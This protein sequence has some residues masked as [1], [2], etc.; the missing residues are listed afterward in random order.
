M[1][2]NPGAAKCGSTSDAP[3][4]THIVALR[5]STAP[6]DVSKRLILCSYEPD[7]VSDDDDGVV[8]VRVG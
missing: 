4:I 3:L 7:R 1:I 6:Q 2:D 8:S 5:L